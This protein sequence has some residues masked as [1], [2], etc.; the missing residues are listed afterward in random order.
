MGHT[1]PCM[2]LV[3]LSLACSLDLRIAGPDGE[4]DWIRM[5]V[6]YG[7]PAFLASI[8]TLIMGRRTYEFAGGRGARFFDGMT[9]YVF[10]ASL[11][12]GPEGQVTLT[13]EDAA[14]FTRK[15]KLASGKDIWL[16]GGHQ[17]SASLLAADLVDE[18]S[19]TVHPVVLGGGPT[20]FGELTERQA[21]LLEEATPHPNGVVQLRYARG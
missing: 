11:P 7:M 21:W 10:S 1:I 13:A 9:N 12:S 15:L 17:L 16:F 14:E 18:V 20:V 2:R 8:D 19:L 5:D 4:I 3:K 6:D